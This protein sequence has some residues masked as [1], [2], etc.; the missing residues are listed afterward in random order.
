M[1][2]QLSLEG[3]LT[4]LRLDAFLGVHFL[5]PCVLGFELLQMFDHGH[6]H[7]AKFSSPLIER[8]RADVVFASKMA[9]ALPASCCFRIAMTWLSMNRDFFIARS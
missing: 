4:D 2:L 6:V 8:G 3:F 1:A 5:K 7:A 9:M